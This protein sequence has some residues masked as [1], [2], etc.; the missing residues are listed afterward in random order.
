MCCSAGRG[1]FLCLVGAAAPSKP[2]GLWISPAHPHPL[3]Q[4]ESEPWWARHHCPYPSTPPRAP[5]C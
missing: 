1:G 5:G 4:Q 3:L 2:T